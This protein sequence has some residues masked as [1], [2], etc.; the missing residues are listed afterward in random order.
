M[1]KI[2]LGHNLFEDERIIDE[3]DLTMIVFE[4]GQKAQ[5]HIPA[6]RRDFLHI[7]RDTPL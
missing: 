6:F 2:S 3:I 4:E 7:R 5:E 1:E